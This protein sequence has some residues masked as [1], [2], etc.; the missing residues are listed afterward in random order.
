MSSCNSPSVWPQT[1][2]DQYLSENDK[3]ENNQ[4]TNVYSISWLHYIFDSFIVVSDL[5]TFV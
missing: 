2:T 3:K 1:Y 5:K 4:L